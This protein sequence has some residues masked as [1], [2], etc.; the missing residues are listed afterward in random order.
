MV[1]LDLAGPLGPIDPRPPPPHLLLAPRCVEP[2]PSPSVWWAPA[3]PCHTFDPTALTSLPTQPP[4]YLPSHPPT[5]RS[6]GDPWA[7]T[8]GRPCPTLIPCSMLKVSMRMCV[9]SIVCVEQGRQATRVGHRGPGMAGDSSPDLRE[10]HPRGNL[11]W[12]SIGNWAASRLH[13]I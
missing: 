12:L 8:H 13:V 9:F 6:Q 5:Y 7:I 10:P 1:T 2:G 11:E 4:T 3:C